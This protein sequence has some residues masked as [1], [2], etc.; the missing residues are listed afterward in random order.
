MAPRL[1]PQ[2]QK[3]S[4]PNQ[5]NFFPDPAPADSHFEG[6]N[7]ARAMLGESIV[8][9]LPE[10][11]K[12]DLRV[13]LIHLLRFNGSPGS[14]YPSTAS[15]ARMAGLSPRSVRR[16]RERLV[17]FGLL[18]LHQPAKGRDVGRY[19]VDECVRF[20]E[21]YRLKRADSTAADV[22]EDD[23]ATRSPMTAEGNLDGRPR[24]ATRS[25]MAANP[26]THDRLKEQHKEQQKAT[27]AAASLFDQ[28]PP[29][30]VDHANGVDRGKPKSFADELGRWLCREVA[31]FA[32]E[33]QLDK[34]RGFVHKHEAKHGPLLRDSEWC[35]AIVAEAQEFQAKA[36]SKVGFLNAWV[37]RAT[38]ALDSKQKE[39]A[40]KAA[41]KTAEVSK[42][43]G[44]LMSAYQFSE[45]EASHARERLAAEVDEDNRA[46]WESTIATATEEMARISAELEA[47]PAAGN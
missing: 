18:V 29:P 11:E 7:V 40:K 34:I 20:S 47:M 42:R 41:N 31:Q 5:P 10:L 19:S 30:P 26:V 35:R 15:V 39:E 23:E 17:S 38:A 37:I 2:S 27:P 6:S 9:F 46:I 33:N 44:A 4:N 16:A 43:R 12:S 24:P 14:S 21:S 1:W 3:M 45:T 8:D 36:D 13:L 25:P 32:T 28:A 22:A